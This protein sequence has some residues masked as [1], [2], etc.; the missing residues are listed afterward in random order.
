M[1]LPFG[2]IENPFAKPVQRSKNTAELIGKILG[3]AQEMAFREALG[4]TPDDLSLDIT[5]TIEAEP[6]L[7]N[8][9]RLELTYNLTEQYEKEVETLRQRGLLEVNKEA[10]VEFIRGIDGLEYPLP[11]LETIAN[12]LIE[13]KETLDIKAE[14]GFTKLILVPFAVS[15]D[16]QIESLQQFLLDYKKRHPDFKLNEKEPAWVWNDATDGYKNADINNDLVYG[17]KKFSKDQTEH[18]GSTKKE[19]LEAQR[20]A[21]DPLAGWKVELFQEDIRDRK[22]IRAGDSRNLGIRS[23]PCAGEGR[24]DGKTHPRPETEAGK[25][26][27]EYL[28]QQLPGEVGQTPEDWMCAFIYHLQEAGEPL[29]N[30]QNGED[31]VAFLTGAW[32]KKSGYV[33]CVYWRAFGA[34][35]SFDWDDP[36]YSS[37]DCGSRS[38]VMV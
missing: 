21:N 37:S 1:S 30:Y 22:I 8:R 3:P 35:A 17:V 6:E 31:S 24:A 9:E 10:G 33:P 5:P 28:A 23:I 32:F 4:S 18:Q 27:N 34:Q 38:V 29:D 26:S 36:S 12:R 13:Q 11:S 15:L 2:S 14:Q 20:N 7:T 19:I 25:S 16:R